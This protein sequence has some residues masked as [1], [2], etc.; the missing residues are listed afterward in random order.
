MGPS[1]HPLLLYVCG[2]SLHEGLLDSV[3]F[4][5]H[6]FL[7]TINKNIIVRYSEIWSCVCAATFH[8]IIH[9]TKTILVSPVMF[10]L[11]KWNLYVDTV[12][13]VWSCG[14]CCVCVGY[15]PLLAH[16]ASRALFDSELCFEVKRVVQSHFLHLRN[17]SQVRSVEI[18]T[19]HSG[20][21]CTSLAASRIQNWF[22]EI[23]L[24]T[25]KAL[26]GLAP[27][28]LT[29]LLIPFVPARNLTS[30]HTA[31]L[32]VARPRLVTKGDRASAIKPLDSGTVYS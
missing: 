9:I 20:F 17:V 1:P 24:L 15:S 21:S 11:W 19:Y 12:L 26:H 31:L 4:V 3:A 22:F 8:H 23:L 5:L 18:W 25:F 2:P 10:T 13:T 28:C 7:L 14:K 27:C 29:E 6:T 30:S 16:A 32:V